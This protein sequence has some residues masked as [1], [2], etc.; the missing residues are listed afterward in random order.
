MTAAPGGAEESPD[1]EK[2]EKQKLERDSDES[3]RSEIFYSDEDS[4]N[5]LGDDDNYGV[6]N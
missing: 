3:S 5:S 4:L 6:N 1:K 2:K